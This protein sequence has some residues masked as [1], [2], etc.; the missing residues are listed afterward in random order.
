MP[1]KVKGLTK[2]KD[3]R[4]VVMRREGTA[5]ARGLALRMLVEIATNKVAEEGALRQR[6]YC[7]VLRGVWLARNRLIP[8]LGKE[9]LLCLLLGF[10]MGYFWHL[11][12]SGVNGVLAL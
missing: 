1:I 11:N 9:M 3:M 12:I 4:M 10:L 6:C 7:E 8:F 2:T 5:C